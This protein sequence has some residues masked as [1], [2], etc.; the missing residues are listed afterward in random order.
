MKTRILVTKNKEKIKFTKCGAD[1]DLVEVFG[2]IK[3]DIYEKRDNSKRIEK[4]KKLLSKRTNQKPLLVV[5]ST[6]KNE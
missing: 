3:F 6:H 5:G 1:E 2:N 4:I